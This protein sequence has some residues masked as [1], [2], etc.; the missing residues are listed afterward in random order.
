MFEFKVIMQ[1]FT[2]N[3]ILIGIKDQF[4]WGGGGGGGVRSLARTFYPLLAQKSSGFTR[5]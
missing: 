2:E 1:R 4:R 3:V 5:I